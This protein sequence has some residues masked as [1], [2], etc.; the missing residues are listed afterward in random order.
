MDHHELTL[1]VSLFPLLE[2]HELH[3]SDASDV[4]DELFEMRQSFSLVGFVFHSVEGTLAAIVDEDSEVLL[5]NATSTFLAILEKF[6]FL[7]DQTAAG[8]VVV[9]ETEEILSVKIDL[10]KIELISA[11]VENEA[12]LMASKE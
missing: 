10:G 3:Q 8:F 9:F 5:V 12:F 6:E 4:S 7:H 11:K 2:S 1:M